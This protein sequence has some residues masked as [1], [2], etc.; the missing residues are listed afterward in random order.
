MVVLIAGG[1]RFLGTVPRRWRIPLDESRA[2][3]SSADRADLERASRLIAQATNAGPRGW[4]LEEARFSQAFVRARLGDFDPDQY[5]G[6]AATL[7]DLVAASGDHEASAFLDL[8]LR[9][10]LGQHARVCRSV[11]TEQALLARSPQAR[12][13]TP[14]LV[15]QTGRGQLA[16]S[17]AAGCTALLPLGP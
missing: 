10:K 12:M 13:I 4:A 1:T 3:L 15:P 5:A 11:E 6:A 9:F 16:P 8:W 2:L 14:H 7:A 17:R